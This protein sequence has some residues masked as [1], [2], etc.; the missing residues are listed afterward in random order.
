MVRRVDNRS[1][2]RT[3]RSFRKQKRTM[4]SITKSR[5]MTNKRK[6]KNKSKRRTNKR[7]NRK[8]NRKRTKRINRKLGGSPG[9]TDMG[10][11]REIFREWLVNNNYGHLCDDVC[12]AFKMAQ[13]PENEWLE[14]IVKI[15]NEGKLVSFMNSFNKFFKLHDLVIIK[16]SPTV[17]GVTYRIG[18][19]LNHDGRPTQYGLQSSGTYGWGRTMP[20]RYTA[21]ELIKVKDL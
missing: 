15:K 21:D 10:G 7:T 1:K 18:R 12:E 19:I 5:K 2:C 8:I 14:E 9:G 17:E 6:R 13:Y 4:R 20:E 3:R 16:D 11:D